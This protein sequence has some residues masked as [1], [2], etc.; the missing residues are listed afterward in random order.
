MI[1]K[2]SQSDKGRRKKDLDLEKVEEGP[3][4]EKDNPLAR[5]ITQTKRIWPDT[6]LKRNIFVSDKRRRRK[7]EL[8]KIW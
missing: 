3:P 5:Y 1:K 4:R 2:R 8:R 7:K 6:L